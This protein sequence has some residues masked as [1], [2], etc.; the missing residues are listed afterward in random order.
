MAPMVVDPDK[1][2]AF[3]TPVAFVDFAGDRIVF[4]FRGLTQGPL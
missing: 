2:R 3:E 4:G 1:V